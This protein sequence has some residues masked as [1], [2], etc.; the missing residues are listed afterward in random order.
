LNKLNNLVSLT[1]TRLRILED[2]ADA[3]KHV[4]VLNDI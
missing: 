1:D 2:E 4:A 3:L